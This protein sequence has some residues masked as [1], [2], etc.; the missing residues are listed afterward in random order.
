M[1]NYD[2]ATQ[3]IKWIKIQSHIS[4]SQIILT[5]FVALFECRVTNFKE[6]GG[7]PDC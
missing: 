2:Q 5:K 1:A 4:F 3:C 7:K 6:L